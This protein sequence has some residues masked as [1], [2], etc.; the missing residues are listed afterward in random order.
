MD[1]VLA[2]RLFWVNSGVYK[3]SQVLLLR[4]QPFQNQGHSSR[5]P[6]HHLKNGLVQGIIIPVALDVPPGVTPTFVLHK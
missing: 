4:A 5:V 6:A 2:I 1:V 3:S